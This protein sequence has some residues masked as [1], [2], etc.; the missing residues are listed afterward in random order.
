MLDLAS[1]LQLLK[2]ASEDGVET[3]IRRY[4]S[5]LREIDAEGLRALTP[6]DLDSIQGIAQRI[7]DSGVNPTAVEPMCDNNTYC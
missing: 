7:V 6:E 5:Q 2:I 1:Q 3:A 4:G